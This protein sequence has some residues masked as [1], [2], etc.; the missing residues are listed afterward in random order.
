MGKECKA[1]Y[2]MEKDGRMGD[3]SE[4]IKSFINPNISELGREVADI[5]GVAFYGISNAP[6]DFKKVNWENNYVIQIYLKNFQL[7]NYDPAHLTALLVLSFD[8]LIRVSI[9]PGGTK[10]LLLLFH[11]RY[12]RT[13]SL[14]K[15]L[16]TLES[17]I[18]GAR[19]YSPSLGILNKREEGERW[20]S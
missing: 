14:S 7:S 15:R 17:M 6:I 20:D 4:Y 5:L 19:S 10:K 8:R 2:T 16:P 12:E 18:E 1:F 11:K 9:N 13:G 3:G